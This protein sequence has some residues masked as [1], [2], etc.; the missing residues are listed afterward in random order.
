MR[1]RLAERFAD[2]EAAWSA[3]R[4]LSR[5]RSSLLAPSGRARVVLAGLLPTLLEAIGRHTDPDRV[6]SNLRAALEHLGAKATVYELWSEQ[7][8]ALELLV[9]LAAGSDV[10]S[11]LL[12]RHPGVFDEVIDRLLTRAP[13]HAQDVLSEVRFA[14]TSAAPGPG[15]LE[16]WALYQL[17]IGISDLGGRSN[18][19]NTARQLAEVSS[20]FLEAWLQ[21]ALADTAGAHG[22]TPAGLQLALLSLGKLGGRELCYGSDVDLLAVYEAEGPAPDGTAP[23]VFCEAVLRKLL[24]RAQAVAWGD[25]P[26]LE[27]DFRLRPGGKSSPLAQSLEAVEG[28]YLAR[29]AGPHAHDFERL[30]LQKARA[31]AGSL[32]L[33]QR[34]VDRVRRAIR[35]RDAAALGAEVER[36][37][38]LQRRAAAEHDLKR[39]RGSLSDVELSTSALA[40]LH[41]DPARD[42]PNTLRALHALQAAGALEAGAY[43]ALSTGYA[44]LRRVELRLRVQRF[45]ARP[46]LPLGHAKRRQLAH[47]LGY[48]DAAVP[49]EEAFLGRAGPPPGAGGPAL[50]GDLAPHAAWLES[51][52]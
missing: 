10:L 7:P 39:G 35:G 16:V 40:L 21:Y 29:G 8:D 31:V 46:L 47:S 12:A 20:G 41:L 14:L 2:P 5:E 18:L 34:A 26:P 22:G 51:E 1:Q 6:L 38:E 23:Q 52:A 3:L 9:A 37:R 43:L 4:D 30:A 19:Q 24:A 48:Q 13:V 32:E 17:Q 45:D 42:E 44:F 27:L 15:Q 36:M 28:Y 50:R 49:A 11:T 33:G 25:A